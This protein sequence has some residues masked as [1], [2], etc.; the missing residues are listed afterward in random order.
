MFHRT[1]MERSAYICAAHGLNMETDIPDEN[2]IIAAFHRLG[3][4]ATV[5]IAEYWAESLGRYQRSEPCRH[6][7][8]V[9]CPPWPRLVRREE[10]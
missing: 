7:R 1:Q 2:P 3:E 8:A 5:D 10:K 6:V 4:Q 9:P